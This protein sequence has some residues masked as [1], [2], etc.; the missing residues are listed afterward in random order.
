MIEQ[1]TELAE[2]VL[3]VYV[4]SNAFLSLFFSQFLQ[5]I[6]GMINALQIIVYTVLFNINV[7]ENANT[8]MMAIL[9]LAALDFI[10]IDQVLTFLKFRETDPFF[11]QTYENGEQYS[12]FADAGY[13]TSVFF[14]N[15]GAIILV[16]LI[17]IA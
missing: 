9:Q 3:V 7:P 6:W 8:L 16:I 15:L 1:I 2:N 14:L 11:L 4:S 12:K 10:E 5:H 17:F 13:E